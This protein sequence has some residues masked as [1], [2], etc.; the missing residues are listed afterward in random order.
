MF[1]LFFACYFFL[2]LTPLQGHQ[3]TKLPL[4]DYFFSP[5]I[6]SLPI[7]DWQNPTDEDLLCLQEFRKNHLQ[8]ILE[9]PFNE[10]P[11]PTDFLNKEF[12]GW[13]TY[14]M[15]N[16]HLLHSI[17]GE[18]KRERTLLYFNND[19]NN[20]KRCLILYATFPKDTARD[21]IQG[22]DY[23]LTALHR[24]GFTG[25]VL[26]Y[27]GGFPSLE[28]GRLLY[29]DVPY[30]FKPFL[31]EE[32]RQLGYENV[33]WLDAC[34]VPIRSLE[35][36]FQFIA[37]SGLCFLEGYRFIWTP[38]NEALSYL[39][40]NFNKKHFSKHIISQVV[41]FHMKNP[42]ARKI[43][44]RWIEYAEEKV[45]FLMGDQIPLGI[46]IHEHACTSCK[47]PPHLYTT[48]PWG[49]GKFVSPNK[50]GQNAVL[51]HQYDFVDPRFKEAAQDFVQTL[52]HK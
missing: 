38:I 1:Q 42:R 4:K 47:L 14:R 52:G 16:G 46:A 45:P 35:P 20:K 18:P 31:F 26:L 50:M 43:L 7:N 8:R 11:F 17:E 24:T 29:A 21:H 34:T 6:S 10:R 48:S 37:K 40:K 3:Q 13:I 32:A 15:G 5:D 44:D 27:K 49:E 12:Y 30:S 25:H 19:P 22:V 39:F 28:N 2:S 9:T 23:I 33:L 41:G 36:I 51:Y